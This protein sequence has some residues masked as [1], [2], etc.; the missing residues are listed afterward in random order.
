MSTVK[1]LKNAVTV[2]LTARAAICATR[3]TLTAK[4]RYGVKHSQGRE[5]HMAEWPEEEL[6]HLLQVIHRGQEPE[7]P[8]SPLRPTY[9]TPD[10][11]RAPQMCFSIDILVTMGGGIWVGA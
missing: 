4:R 5:Y 3:T 1:T 11:P 10:T 2:T 7:T 9:R 6:R 8:P